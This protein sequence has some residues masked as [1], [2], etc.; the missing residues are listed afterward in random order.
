[1][2]LRGDARPLQGEARADGQACLAAAAPGGDRGDGVIGL[3]AL[4]ASKLGVALQPNL[5]GDRLEHVRRRPGT[6]HHRRDSPQGRLLAGERAQ[7]RL[8]LLGLPGPQLAP[9]ARARSHVA[10]AR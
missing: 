6:R 1:M 7:L 9:R 5:A 4:H 8:R 10:R 3:E 2:N